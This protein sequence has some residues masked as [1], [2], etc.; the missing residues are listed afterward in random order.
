MSLGT[1]QPESA[2]DH[3]WQY[4]PGA[5]GAILLKRSPDGTQES[6]HAVHVLRL[7]VSSRD[8]VFVVE[9]LGLSAKDTVFQYW[10]EAAEVPELRDQLTD[11]A[12]RNWSIVGVTQRHWGAKWYVAVVEVAE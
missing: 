6:V 1:F 3:T 2:Y 12:G 7:D 9:A 11:G 5:E 4:T 10:P 8:Y